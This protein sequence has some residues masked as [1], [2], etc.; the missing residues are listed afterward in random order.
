MGVDATPGSAHAAPMEGKTVPFRAKSGRLVGAEDDVVA[1]SVPPL[2]LSVERGKVVDE[3]SPPSV[4]IGVWLTAKCEI[5]T[6]SAGQ[7]KQQAD[8]RKSFSRSKYRLTN[9][10]RESARTRKAA[11]ICIKANSDVNA[12]VRKRFLTGPCNPT[13]VRRITVAYLGQG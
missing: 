1:I 4:R 3:V 9:H 6:L 2:T 7:N 11:V 5:V 10:K 8:Y 13:I 12:C